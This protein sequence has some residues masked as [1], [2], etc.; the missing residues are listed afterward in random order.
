MINPAPASYKARPRLKKFVTII[1]AI[2]FTPWLLL[3]PIAFAGEW[4]TAFGSWVC[5][6]RWRFRDW[7]YEILS[8]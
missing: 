5:P 3:V 1:T 4:I 8:K 6:Y 7:V 2:P